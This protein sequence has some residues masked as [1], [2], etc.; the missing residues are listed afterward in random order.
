M[1]KNHSRQ[2]GERPNEIRV[3]LFGGGNVG[4]SALVIQF[5][6]NEFVEEYDPTIEDRFLVLFCVLFFAFLFFVFEEMGFLVI[7][8]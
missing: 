8:K 4:K 7:E 3:A 6:S 5:V 1:G 2:R